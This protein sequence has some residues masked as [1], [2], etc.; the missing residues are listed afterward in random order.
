MLNK[1]YRDGD[2]RCQAIHQE[3]SRSNED[4]FLMQ[5]GHFTYGVFDGST[6]Y[7]KYR[8]GR[9]RSAGKVAADTAR[10][11]F[12]KEGDLFDLIKKG[13]QNIKDLILKEGKV[14]F[15]GEYDKVDLW[16]TTAMIFRINKDEIEWIQIDDSPIVI[17]K[18][19]NT[20][21]SLLNDIDHDKDSLKL[22]RQLADE[23]IED[24]RRD[25]RMDKQINKTR[26]NGNVRYGVLNGEDKAM[27]FIKQG[28]YPLK[29]VK[30]I[31]IFTDGFLIPNER[32]EQSEDYTEAVE[33]FIKN[34]YDLK[35]VADKIREMEQTDPKCHR[36]V[37][38]KQHDDMSAV[39]ITFLDK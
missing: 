26:R 18:K 36:Y 31:L 29:D 22:W 1:I 32:P 4:S 12:T 35:P 17:I 7:K 13:N 30:S 37:R 19:D 24:I 28:K 21:E 9:N 25:P 39:A 23:G 15:T 33:M 34:N 2:I 14:D 6:G 27:E 3:G 8:D 11:I 10:D 16:N 38:F 5:E 20:W